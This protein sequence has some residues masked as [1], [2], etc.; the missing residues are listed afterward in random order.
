MKRTKMI[1]KRKI[2]KKVSILIWKMMKMVIIITIMIK[3]KR[4][5]TQKRIKRKPKR[6]LQ[7]VMTQIEL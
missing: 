3:K 5:K 7:T 4:K 6:R 1:R 2:M